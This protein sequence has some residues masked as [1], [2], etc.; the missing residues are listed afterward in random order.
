MPLGAAGSLHAVSPGMR[1]GAALQTTRDRIEQG[2]SVGVRG[3]DEN[4]SSGSDLDDLIGFHD[5]DLRALRA[6][7]ARS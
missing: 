7:M 2:P 6:T 5:G 4:L 1:A 3:R